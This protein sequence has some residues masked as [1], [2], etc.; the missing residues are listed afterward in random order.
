MFKFIR[1]LTLISA[2]LITTTSVAFANDERPVAPALPD[3]VVADCSRSAVSVLEWMND[4]FPVNISVATFAH[5][6][7]IFG[8]QHEQVT[9]QRGKDVPTSGYSTFYVPTWSATQI[10]S[11]GH[12]TTMKISIDLSQK[13]RWGDFLFDE[14]RASVEIRMFHGDRLLSVL[15]DHVAV[16]QGETKIEFKTPHIQNIDLE[17]FLNVKKMSIEQYLGYSDSYGTLTDEEVRRR[18]REMYREFGDIS[19]VVVGASIG[20]TIEIPWAFTNDRE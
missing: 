13:T 1:M 11:L 15:T 20:C 3:A 16:R 8:E 18:A 2:L 6:D 19:G 9:L 7:K 17:N 14:P 4:Q 12:S 5:V 10:I